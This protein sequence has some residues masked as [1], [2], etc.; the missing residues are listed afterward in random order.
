[1]PFQGSKSTVHRDGVFEHYDRQLPAI[2]D[3]QKY[4]ATKS[5]PY[6]RLRL[7]F[8]CFETRY[9][10]GTQKSFNVALVGPGLSAT[11]GLAFEAVTEHIKLVVR[12][13]MNP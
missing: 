3:A 7:I 5:E 1:M 13:H 2:A 6:D 11:K 4:G 12:Q 9:R 10:A 8:R